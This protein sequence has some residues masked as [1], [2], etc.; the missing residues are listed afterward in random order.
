MAGFRKYHRGGQEYEVTNVLYGFRNGEPCMRVDM[1]GN[2]Q[3]FFAGSVL[4]L[5]AQQLED[6]IVRYWY[7]YSG[8]AQESFNLA[9]QA[10]SQFND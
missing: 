7:V 2:P 9:S 10:L 4:V 6:G 1:R 8:K 5:G 3:T